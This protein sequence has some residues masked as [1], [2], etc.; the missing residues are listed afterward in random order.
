[1]VPQKLA[2][3]TEW[4]AMAA[5]AAALLRERQSEYG[6]WLTS[7]TKDL[8]YEA[9]QQEMNTYLT[10]MLVDLLS[11]L[12]RQRSLEDVLVRARQHLAAQIESDGLVRY[13]GLPNGPT[14]GTLGAVVTPAADDTSLAWS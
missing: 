10:S 14:M 4:E 7:Y 2:S 9:P 11:P 8:R 12:A 6:Y 1:M 13:H 3:V 5:R